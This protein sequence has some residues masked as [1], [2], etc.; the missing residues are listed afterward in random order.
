MNTK[1]S[2]LHITSY[3]NT[4][5]HKRKSPEAVPLIPHPLIAPIEI[6]Y[7]IRLALI[8]YPLTILRVPHISTVS[9]I[10]ASDL[11]SFQLG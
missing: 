5:T 11:L 4:H 9:R 10:C 1:N 7:A 2:R 3:T 6:T 8:M